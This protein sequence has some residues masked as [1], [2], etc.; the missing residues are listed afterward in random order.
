[1]AIIENEERSS[2]IPLSRIACKC[3]VSIQITAKFDYSNIIN[4]VEDNVYFICP[5]F[6][7]QVL[8]II[9][10]ISFLLL[11]SALNVYFH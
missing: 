9:S 1:M 4:F 7:K 10:Y 2:I 11:Q 3:A 6:Q 8:S 5:Y